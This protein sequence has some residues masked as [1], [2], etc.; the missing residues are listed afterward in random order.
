M[1]QSYPTAIAGL[2]RQALLDEVGPLVRAAA[3]NPAAARLLQVQPLA[4]DPAA[5]GDREGAARWLAGARELDALSFGAFRYVTFAN[6]V[7]VSPGASKWD[8]AIFR[9]MPSP[10]VAGYWAEIAAY[11]WASGPYKD[12]GDTYL[13]AFDAGRA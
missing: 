9:A 13:Q 6:L 1:T 7:R 5:A 11:P 2:R 12:A 8:P 10:L 3:Q 4:S